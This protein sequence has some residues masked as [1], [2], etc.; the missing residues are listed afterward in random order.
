MTPEDP[1]PNAHG[2]S[3]EPADELAPGPAVRR[4]L[5]VQVRFEDTNAA[6]HVSNIAF[7]GYAELGR[8][9]LMRLTSRDRDGPVLART[10]IDFHDQ[11]LFGMRVVVVSEAARIGRSS[12]DLRQE[13][14]AD[15][16]KVA[17]VESVVVW[18]DFQSQRPVP[19]PDEVRRA[20]FGGE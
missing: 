12:I 4:E 8:V 17:T 14:L 1:T 16:R 13:I 2:R 6:G 18:F 10:A 15:G 3:D 11:I 5:E 20:L 19:V 7:A 9:D